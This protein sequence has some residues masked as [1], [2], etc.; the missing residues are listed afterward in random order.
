MVPYSWILNKKGNY[1][2]H[3][4]KTIRNSLLN[5]IKDNGIDLHTDN[6]LLI[7]LNDYAVEG[8]YSVM[9][10]DLENI[11]NIF[12]LLSDMLNEA[13]EIVGGN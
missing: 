5:I 2:G 10:D 3:L 13:S 11:Q 8:R 6:D 1:Y 4:L 7:E 12:V 9:H